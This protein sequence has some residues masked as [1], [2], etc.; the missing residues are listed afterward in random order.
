[1]VDGT[2]VNFSVISRVNF[3]DSDAVENGLFLF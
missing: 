2:H 1:M 3:L